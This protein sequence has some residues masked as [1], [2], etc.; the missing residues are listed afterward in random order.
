MTLAD[1]IFWWKI[2][3]IHFYKRYTD[4]NSFKHDYCYQIVLLELKIMQLICSWIKY[5]WQLYRIWNNIFD[6]R[7]YNKSYM[8]LYA[9]H[10]LFNFFKN[11]INLQDVLTYVLLG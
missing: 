10:I 9:T 2:F 8:L 7:K 11:L 6:V 1:S 4:Y 5:V 3:Q